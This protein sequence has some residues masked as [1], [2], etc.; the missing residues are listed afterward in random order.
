MTQCV[1]CLALAHVVIPGSW[2]GAPHLVPYSG[3]DLLLPLSASPCLC[4]LLHASSISKKEN[5]KKKFF[6][7]AFGAFGVLPNMKYLTPR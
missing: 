1:K 2:D 5:L 4:S 7:R 6:G 3:R